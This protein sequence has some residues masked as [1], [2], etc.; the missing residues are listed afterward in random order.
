[1]ENKE[2]KSK[3]PRCSNCGGAFTYIRFR[4]KM[5]ICRS[6]GN[7]EPL[8]KEEYERKKK[9]EEVERINKAVDLSEE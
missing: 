7:I 2:E 6:C 1:M 9:K 3:K 8:N 4:D 5:I